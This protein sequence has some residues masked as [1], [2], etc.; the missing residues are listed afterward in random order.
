V[1]AHGL[2]GVE[3]IH[4]CRIAVDRRLG[5]ER[6][7]DDGPTALDIAR[8]QGRGAVTQAIGRGRRGA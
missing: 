4:T 1:D 2:A 7:L 5:P 6:R 8:D 3:H